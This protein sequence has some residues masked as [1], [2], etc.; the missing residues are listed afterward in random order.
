LGGILNDSNSLVTSAAVLGLVFAFGV[1]VVVPVGFVVLVEGV[2]VVVVGILNDSSSLVT[3]SAFLGLSDTGILKS[4]NSLFISIASSL[5]ENIFIKI[6][7]LYIN[8]KLK[9]KK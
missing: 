8:K 6:L 5:L 9:N 2:T 1:E 3:S 7:I 4:C